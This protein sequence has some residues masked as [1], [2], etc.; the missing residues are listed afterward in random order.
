MDMNKTKQS[1]EKMGS[2]NPMYGKRHS[3]E[4]KQKISNTQRA[5]YTAIRKALAEQELG[6]GR[7]G[8]G[9]RMH[10]WGKAMSPSLASASTLGSGAEALGDVNPRVPW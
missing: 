9:A 2:L 10:R 4:T 8:T 5:R 1:M 6:S 3:E 7:S